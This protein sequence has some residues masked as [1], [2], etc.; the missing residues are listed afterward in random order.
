MTQGFN[1]IRTP[2]LFTLTGDLLAALQ[3]VEVDTETG[4]ITGMDK[5]D[6]LTLDTRDKL[7]SCAHAIKHLERIADATDAEIKA[8]QRRKDVTKKMIDRLKENSLVAMRVLGETKITDEAQTAT[9]TVCKKAPSVEIQDES[10]LPPVFVVVKTATAVDKIGIAR[11]LKAGHDVPG[12]RL[13]TGQM[14]LK[15]K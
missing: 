10:K 13:V 8:M 14:Y 5:V 12:A 2:S 15:I 9:L 7:I 6:A 11:E 1:P 4:E 3:A